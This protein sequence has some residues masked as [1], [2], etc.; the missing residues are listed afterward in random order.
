M[1]PGIILETQF[2]NNVGFNDSEEVNEQ[3]AR[4]PKQLL[5]STDQGA[6]TQVWAAISDDVPQP[7]ATGKFLEEV[8][9]SEPKDE[10]DKPDF[11]GYVEHTYDPV[12]AA[13]LWEVSEKL[14]GVSV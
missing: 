2:I 7:G 13:R 9:V 10:T 4:L 3:L 1:H 8:A 11:R 5:K 14:L 6:A 12:S